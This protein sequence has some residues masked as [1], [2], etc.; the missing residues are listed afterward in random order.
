MNQEVIDTAVSL[1]KTIG[2]VVGP[3]GRKGKGDLSD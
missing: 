1:G 3:S 2:K